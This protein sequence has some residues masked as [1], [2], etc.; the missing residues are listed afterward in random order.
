MYPFKR[1]Y[2]NGLHEST[3]ENFNKMHVVFDMEKVVC[4]IYK[5][6]VEVH[7]WMLRVVGDCFTVCMRI[8]GG[9]SVRIK[10]VLVIFQNLNGNYLI[11]GMPDN[12]E[13]T[14]RCSLKKLNDCS[15]F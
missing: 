6:L 15:N 5:D 11:S 3:I 2:D 7:I 8:S 13:G 4:W 1:S 10:K 9:Q 12:I 14:C